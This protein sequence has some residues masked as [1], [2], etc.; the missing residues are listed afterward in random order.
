MALEYRYGTAFDIAGTKSFRLSSRQQFGEIGG[1]LQNI[2]EDL[3]AFLVPRKGYKLVQVDQSGAEALIVAYLCRKGNYRSLFDLGIKPH[4]YMALNMFVEDFKGSHPA[5]RY[6]YKTP[7]ELITYPEWP[8]LN[9]FISK[10]PK[11]TTK[12]QLGKKVA[13]AKA[14]NTGPHTFRKTVLQDTAGAINLT[15][16]QAKHFLGTHERLFPEIMEWQ[17][18]TIQTTSEKHVLYNLFGYPRTFHGRWNAEVE[19]EALS[20]IP[21]ST[22][23]TLTSIVFTELWAYI[24]ANK[25][26]WMPLVNVHD[27]VVTECP[28]SQVQDCAYVINK[29]FA[30][31]L[32]APSGEVFHMKSE[33]MAGDS[34][35]KE[36][37]EEVKV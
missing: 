21:Q 20:Y 10:D 1:N 8:A 28:P 24:C 34:W 35:C 17:A 32:T 5:E 27:A 2:P 7:Q 13:H 26:D 15:F 25:L 6:L 19:R 14:Y 30:R 9:K 29:L 23:G 4:T 18:Q 12:Y 3:R 31:P 16:A 11:N 36:E 33:A 37:M 22:V